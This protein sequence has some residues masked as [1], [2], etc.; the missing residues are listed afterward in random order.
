MLAV[1]SKVLTGNLNEQMKS[2]NVEPE[3]DDIWE[4][5]PSRADDRRNYAWR[6]YRILDAKRNCQHILAVGTVRCTVNSGHSFLKPPVV[7]C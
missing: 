2:E 1:A 4:R 5:L 3:V 7:V 6:M